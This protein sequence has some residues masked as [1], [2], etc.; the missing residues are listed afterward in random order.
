M[1]GIALALSLTVAA[2]ADD[3]CPYVKPEDRQDCYPYGDVTQ[4]K[5]EAH[6]CCYNQAQEGDPWCYYA[7]KPAPSQSVC[8]STTPAS[9]IDCFPEV[10]PCY[11]PMLDVPYPT[12]PV[13]ISCS[14]MSK[15][16]WH[17]AAAGM[18]PQRMAFLFASDRIG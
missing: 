1:L 11:R 5:C 7:P 2:L 8:T 18:I 14:L 6:G 4:S 3:S 17:A 9:R 15:A 16:A 12:L 13:I 10:I